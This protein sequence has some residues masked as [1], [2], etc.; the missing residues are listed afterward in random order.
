MLEYLESVPI[1]QD[2]NLADFRFPVQYVLRPNLD[3][4]GF[5]GQ[6]ASGVR[7]ARATR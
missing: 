5:A 1:A 4:R 3:Y 6:I 7:Q 2:R